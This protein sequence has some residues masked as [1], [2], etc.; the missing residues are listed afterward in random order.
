MD[1]FVVM[2]ALVAVELPVH[3]CP[4]EGEDCLPL[5]GLCVGET[6][7]V[8]AVV[9]EE[10]PAAVAADGDDRLGHGHSSHSISVV[11]T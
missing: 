2:V 11:V 4:V 9:A 1:F 10:P 8:S 5:G 3:A 6:C 7:G